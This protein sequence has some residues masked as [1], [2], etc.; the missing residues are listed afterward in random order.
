ME[1]LDTPLEAR[2]VVERWRGHFNTVRTHSAFGYRPPTPE[3][4]TSGNV[5]GPVQSGSAVDGIHFAAHSGPHRR[6]A[7]KLASGIANDCADMPERRTAPI[8]NGRLSWA[9]ARK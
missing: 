8:R 9:Q 3:A 4:V 2:V 1:I 6:A 5:A 7:F